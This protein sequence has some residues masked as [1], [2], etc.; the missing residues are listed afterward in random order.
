MFRFLLING[1]HSFYFIHRFQF[2]S[3]QYL[4]FFFLIHYILSNKFS[5]N[6][7]TTTG[8]NSLFIFISIYDHLCE[9]KINDFFW[10]TIC[11]VLF[12]V[13]NI[14]ISCEEVFFNLIRIFWVSLILSITE[15]FPAGIHSEMGHDYDYA[16]HSKM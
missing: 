3:I 2:Q 1:V 14:D 8:K 11:T 12:L 5:I 7:R 10:N 16:E 13:R 9:T 4:T 15:I 6:T